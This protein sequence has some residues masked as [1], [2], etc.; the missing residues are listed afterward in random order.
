MI[1]PT[2]DTRPPITPQLA[3]RVAIFGGVALV[4][5]AVIFFRLWYLQV[6]SGDQYLT[7]ANDNRVREV[8]IQAPRGEIVDRNGDPLVSNRQ[9]IVVTLAPSTLP[10]SERA[11]AAAWGQDA[12]RRAAKPE[13]QRGP[14][15]PI[16][17]I[18]NGDLRVRY[19]RLG[20]VLNRSAASIHRDVIQQL[21]QVPYSDVRLGTDVPRSVLNYIAE[22]REK[23]PGLRIEEIYLRAYPRSELAAQLVGTVGEISPAQL[24]KKRYRDVTQGTI[25]GQDGL[26]YEYDAYLRGKDGMRR[27][28]VDAVG[29]P[30]GD[31]REVK[32]TAGRTVK[33][34]LDLKLQQTAQKALENVGGGRKGAA[35]AL[36]P[37][38]GEVLALA[39]S[40]SF[41]PTLFTKPMTQKQYE[42]LTSEE[43]GAPLFNR[44]I[45]SAYPT[46]ST[47]KIV[48]ALA[49]LE[50]GTRRAD[51]VINDGGFFEL[52]PS[53]YQNAGGTA[54]GAVDLR[55]AMEVSSDVYFYQLGAKLNALRGQVL[56]SWA[57]RLGFGRRTGIDLP[58]EFR[59]LVPDRQ[60]RKEIGEVEARCQKKKKVPSCG[61]SDGRA[62][63]AGD[64]VQLA[65]GQG[66]LQATPLQLATAYAT[67]AN[68]GKRF[69][70]H[71]GLEVEDSQGRTIQRI[72][73]S[74]S[75]RVNFDAANRQ[76]I[77]D[78]LRLAAQGPSGTSTPVFKGWPH[79]RYPVYGKT[80]TAQTA[81]GD[82]SWYAAYVADDDRPIVVVVTVEQGGWGADTAAPITR[83]ML[84]RWFLNK[85]GGVFRGDS[86]TN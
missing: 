56:Q 58:A 78:G 66:D 81:K 57:R 20:R 74:E 69:K 17:A 82:Q 72:Q 28:Q 54:N 8:R 14:Q 49:A 39:S 52:G 62:W 23:F 6:L 12:G 59:G 31:L 7:E 16:P 10:E 43:T 55:K 37:T 5:F 27:I 83:Q 24:R 25:I 60:W 35:V 44:A 2:R 4:L 63:D 70:P 64:N 65:I 21:A 41:D 79:D 30:K 50:S 48:T 32:P 13:G 9:A 73:S 1:D 15:V 18:D 75:T 53:K 51:E 40:P 3:L 33:L 68:G 26:E 11:M 38:N 77:M 46:A 67:L 22:R 47:F 45:G 42:A 71:V 29:R 85:D 76:A 19:R 84:S 61:I 36:D 34:S 86:Q 80:G